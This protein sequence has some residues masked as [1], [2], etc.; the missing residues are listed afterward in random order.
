MYLY[1]HAYVHYI[2]ISCKYAACIY[3]L[4]KQMAFQ[5]SR[6]RMWTEEPG[7]LQ[8]IEWQRV[9]RD[10]SDLA[11]MK[12]YRI[13]IRVGIYLHTHHASRCVCVSW[14]KREV[15]IRSWRAWVTSSYFFLSC[16]RPSHLLIHCHHTVILVFLWQTYSIGYFFLN[17]NY[18]MPQIQ[19]PTSKFT[20]CY[21]S[22]LVSFRRSESAFWKSHFLSF[23]K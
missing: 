9:R 13:Y 19:L 17:N 22:F 6:L 3:M 1:L 23:V 14:N 10:W 18:N 5:S 21:C 11:H 16:Y 2:T 8:S 20:L 15:P 4:E 7:S 12:I